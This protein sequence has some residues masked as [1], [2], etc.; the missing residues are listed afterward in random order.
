[1]FAFSPFAKIFLLITYL[2]ETHPLTGRGQQTGSV[3]G[4]VETI[5]D[6][7]NQE[8]TN[9]FCHDYSTPF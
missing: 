6:F 8:T 7:V 4:Q 1:M 5:L 2:G 9:G 3:K